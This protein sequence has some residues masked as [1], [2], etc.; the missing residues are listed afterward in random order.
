MQRPPADQWHPQQPQRQRAEPHAVAAGHRHG[1]D[2]QGRQEDRLA[3]QAFQA[4]V[5]SGWMQVRHG[6]A[7]RVMMRE[8]RGCD[9][10]HGLRLHPPALTPP[11]P[12]AASSFAPE[13]SCPLSSHRNALPLLIALVLTLAG[14]SSA[15]P[16]ENAPPVSLPS[17]MGTWHVIAHVPYFTERGHVWAHDD[18]MLRP[19]GKIAVHYTYRTGFHAPVRSLDA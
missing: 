12:A 9:A 15:P 1:Q 7:L 16:A 18:Y 5:G 13:W 6:V 19:D 8:Q 3:Q 10:S 2:Q 4:R 17:V 11:S 14:C